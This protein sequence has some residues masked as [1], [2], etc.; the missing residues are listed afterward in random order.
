MA[1]SWKMG[2]KLVVFGVY[3]VLVLLHCH[4]STCGAA[5][6]DPDNVTALSPDDSAAAKPVAVVTTAGNADPSAAVEP[7]EFDLTKFSSPAA[8]AIQPAGPDSTPDADAKLNTPVQLQPAVQ[9][10]PVLTPAQDPLVV[11]TGAVAAPDP[12][13]PVSMAAT[14]VE[15][16][17]QAVAGA[18]TSV[19]VVLPPAKADPP[20]PAAPQATTITSTTTT[21][22][23]PPPAKV[24]AS[25]AAAPAPTTVASEP[26]PSTIMDLNLPQ[27]N[28]AIQGEPKVSDSPL[29]QGDDE[30]EDDGEDYYRDTTVEPG[31]SLDQDD[32]GDQGA[33]RRN[34]NNDL[35][36]N[37]VTDQ[38]EDD[39]DDMYDPGKNLI[40][41]RP[42]TGE[43]P[44]KK[45]DNRLQDVNIYTNPDEDTHFFFHLVIIAFLVAIVYI[46]YHNKRKIFLL[47]S[48]RR[49]RDGICSRGVEYRRLDQNVNEAMPSLKMTNDYIF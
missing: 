37:A 10:D 6:V 25:T 35:D 40:P 47:A 36:T 27:K 33:E 16:A 23:A 41:E 24:P 7:S 5:P 3:T 45:F 42:L 43:E 39:D 12:A 28:T 44:V 19:N 14:K 22:T 1:T 46:T 30:E 11:Q 2:R 49:W 18:N 29:L 32:G 48:S 26:D 21:T 9:S 13:Q 38:D 31:V 34:N 4:I 17:I 20:A 8:A 15:E